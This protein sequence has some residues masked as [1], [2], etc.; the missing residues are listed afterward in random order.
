MIDPAKRGT[1][2]TLVA[3]GDV[4]FAFNEI[5]RSNSLLTLFLPGSSFSTTAG[6]EHRR[7]PVSRNAQRT[8]RVQGKEQRVG[9]SRLSGLSVFGRSDISLRA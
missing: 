8:I 6:H 9:L 4:S 2:N 5:I 7:C 3:K 1:M